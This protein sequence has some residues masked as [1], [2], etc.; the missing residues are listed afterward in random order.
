MDV[1]SSYW[2]SFVFLIEGNRYIVWSSMYDG[3]YYRG[4]LNEMWFGRLE[5][6]YF[7]F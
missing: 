1:F 2:L 7:W 3:I 4:R 5:I 6:R